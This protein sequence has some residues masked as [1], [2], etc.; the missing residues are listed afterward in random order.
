MS[1]KDQSDNCNYYCN[2]TGS[3]LLDVA[4]LM[5]ATR[6]V[7]I[8]VIDPSTAVIIVAV[9]TVKVIP[10]NGKVATPRIGK[11]TFL[12]GSRLNIQLGTGYPLS[13][14]AWAYVI[15]K[16]AN[17]SRKSSS[18]TV[19]GIHLPPARLIEFIR[20]GISVTSELSI[21][22]GSFGFSTGLVIFSAQP[23]ANRKPLH[24]KYFIKTLREVV[25]CMIF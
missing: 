9:G 2:H 18:L 11:I 25:F 17:G 15:N 16:L 7:V 12:F 14:A 1:N 23:E 13:A 22:I 24:V 21:S 19:F 10:H 6:A 3:G 4:S 8:I 20:D 5:A